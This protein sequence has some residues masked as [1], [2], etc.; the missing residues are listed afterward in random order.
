VAK[1]G[2]CMQAGR[3]ASLPGN[4]KITNYINIIIASTLNAKIIITK[5]NNYNNY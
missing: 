5:K 2:A 3:N 4:K 1:R